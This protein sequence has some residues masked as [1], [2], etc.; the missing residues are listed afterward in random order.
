MNR[1]DMI[2]QLAALEALAGA[3][4]EALKE[5][6]AAE[7][8]DNGTTP[9]WRTADGTLVVGSVHGD[10]CEVTD[11][12][13]LMAWLVEQYPQMV[14]TVVVPRDPKVVAALLADVAASGPRPD[15]VTGERPALQPGEQAA[16][17]ADIPGVVYVQGGLFKTITVTVESTAKRRLKTEARDY[18]AGISDGFDLGRL[19]R[20]DYAPYQ[21]NYTRD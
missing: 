14:H 16:N 17:A 13:A 8:A 20:S 12:D 10:R 2:R 3:M 6:A 18:L 5:E 1:A 7:H 19:F 9:S 4:R 15:P 11:Q 21:R